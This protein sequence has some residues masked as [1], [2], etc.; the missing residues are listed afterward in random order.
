MHRRI[1]GD[2]EMDD[3]DAVMCQHKHHE[4][5]LALQRTSANLVVLPT[6]RSWPG[7]VCHADST[8][9]TRRCPSK[10]MA[11]AIRGNFDP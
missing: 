9:I 7:A 6:G 3:P 11:F 8:P 2:V 5:H 1:L 4:E 10:L